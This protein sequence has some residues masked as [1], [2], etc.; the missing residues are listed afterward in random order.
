VKSRFINI[1]L[2]LS[3]C[4][5]F[6]STIYSQNLQFRHYSSDEGFTGA[7]FKRIVQDSLGFI[8]I[9]S[10]TGLYQFDGYT[11]HHLTQEPSDSSNFRVDIGNFPISVDVT[12]S[13]WMALNDR[14]T[15]YVHRKERFTSYML[16]DKDNKPLSLAFSDDTKVWIGT[17]GRGLV[18]F[19][20]EEKS[21]KVFTNSISAEANT[22]FDLVDEGTMLLAGTSSGLWKFSLKDNKF[23]R[24]MTGISE[25]SPLYTGE[26]RKIFVHSGYYW[27]WIDQKF[28]KVRPNGAI[29]DVLDFEKLH[30]QF[31]G[32]K[33]FPSAEIKSIT[34]DKDGKFWMASQGLGLFCYDPATKELLNFRKSAK[35]EVDD[36][37]LPSDVLHHVMIDRDNNVWFTTVNKGIGQLKKQSL[38]F[39]NYLHG[40]SSTGIGLIVGEK[41]SLLAVGTNGSGLWTTDFSADNLQN[42]KFERLD[43]KPSF[44]G[45]ENIIEMSVGKKNLWLGTLNAGVVGLPIEQNGS[46][47][48]TPRYHYF[49][50]SNNPTSL[51]ANFITA[52]WENQQGYLWI[53]TYSSGIGIIKPDAAE[54]IFVNHRNTPDDP[55]SLASN[56]IRTI[57]PQKDGSILIASFNGL[58]RI[59]NPIAPYRNLKIEHLAEGHYG[60]HLY[61]TLD[62]TL[63]MS[64]KT[65]LL[66]GVKVGDSYKFEK[67]PLPGNPNVTFAEEDLLGRIW[68]MSYEG[69][70]F[71]D[72]KK[73]FALVFKKED[74]LPSSRSVMAA[75]SWQTREGIM[76][77]SNGEGVTIFNPLTLKINDSK[78]KPV[79]TQL[80]INNELVS[81]HA[82]ESQFQIPESIKSLRHLEL[83]YTQNILELEFSSMDMTAPEKNQYKYILEGF[84]ETWVNT[85]WN[86]RKATYTNLNPGNYTFKIMASNRDG[87]WSDRV[88][89]INITV[90]PP[91]WNTWWAY[92]IYAA[93][94]VGILFVA[95]RSILKEERLKA[96]L[97]IDQIELE[98]KEIALQKAQEVDR[99]KSAFFTNISHE[100]RTPLTLIQGPVQML[101]EKFSADP[102]VKHQLML[103]QNNTHLLLKLINQ[104]LELARLES[105]NLTVENEQTDLNLFL[106]SILDHFESE[107]RQKD[108]VLELQLPP[109]FYDLSFDKGKVETILINLLGNSMKFTPANGRVTLRAN[110]LMPVHENNGTPPLLNISVAD[111][112]IGIPAEN[113]SLIFDRFYQ[114]NETHKQIGT[115]IGLALV[116]E[117]TQ[118]LKGTVTVKS[119]PGTGSE[120][121]LKIPVQVV[122]VHDKELAKSINQSIPVLNAESNGIDDQLGMAP[123]ILV[124]EDNQ[125]LRKFIIDSFDSLY[126]FIEAA[127]GVEGLEKAVNEI[128]E[129]IIS[130]IMMPEM[131]GITMSSKIKSDIRTSHI[132]ILFLTAKATEKSKLSGLQTGAEDY[133]T[134]PFNKDELIL[135]VKNIILSREK[136]RQ[137]LRL[138][139][140][141]ESPT[142]VAES[143]D[144]QFL[145]K[146]KEIIHQR[147]NDPKLS[148]D[149]LALDVALSRTQLYR[150]ITG[151]TGSSVNEL[152]RNFRLQR[153]AQLLHQGWGSVSD[154]SY[155]V[156]FSNLSYF[157]KCFK[158]QFGVLPSEYQTK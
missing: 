85:D 68:C 62:G 136:I 121:T 150:K 146:V 37:S 113:Q 137:K 28:M 110:L 74:G 125:D 123:K 3:L 99:L 130:D 97:R 18:C 139:F 26:V 63:L 55:N 131:D 70:F 69:L 109:E 89:S 107:A 95:R 14:I 73:K 48:N 72:R 12:G 31:D 144:E 34:E 134:K 52:F 100:F 41:S 124:V 61:A 21:F 35:N 59:V 116:K 33:K 5:G 87:V 20:R 45:F 57:L 115:G 106:K 4:A 6:Y 112:G 22:I 86:N 111:T 58:D 147:L 67:V 81:T 145:V 92:S 79:I 9:T 47:K 76:I 141:K 43:M 103:I 39:N 10:A 117:L 53:G 40:M 7:A 151:L 157:S 93:I 71:Y 155:E 1:A 119:A 154:V 24:P 11:F 94:I 101:L 56:G 30:Q 132:P 23:F 108:M 153:A 96:S 133:L 50:D 84:N 2:S 15:T 143:A 126:H 156:G 91:P 142:I 120:F 27:L 44:K 29:V 129:L 25:S 60:N 114:V 149:T 51:A 65:G 32:E 64:T 78:P 138:D 135:K 98:K 66:E 105:G 158:E 36:H 46:L 88:T 83:N 148:V 8:W 19:D 42:L 152:I 38:I 90:L 127:N 102:K 104:L 16:P 13:I 128:P 80:K 118:L 122:G 140:L 77:F 17:A 54:N 75:R 49:N 82:A